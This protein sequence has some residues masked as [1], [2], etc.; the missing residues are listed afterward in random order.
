MSRELRHRTR[1]CSRG[2]LQPMV[3]TAASAVVS[4]RRGKRRGTGKHRDGDVLMQAAKVVGSKWRSN[5]DAQVNR[6]G[7]CRGGDDVGRRRV[8]PVS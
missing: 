6:G 2:L 7:G 4:R 3:A 8:L 5:R 1:Q